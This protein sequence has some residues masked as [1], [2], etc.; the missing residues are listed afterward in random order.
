M[1][2]F[3]FKT[4]L[5]TGC[6]NLRSYLQLGL[7]QTEV[8]FISAFVS[9]RYFLTFIVIGHMCISKAE[10]EELQQLGFL[11]KHPVSEVHW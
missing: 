6:Y 3:F 11:Q 1:A 10:I 9:Q 7:M 4:N 2:F 5:L 8:L